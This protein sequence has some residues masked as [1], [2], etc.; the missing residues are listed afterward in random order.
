MTN[1]YVTPEMIQS[2]LTESYLVKRKRKSFLETVLELYEKG[3]Y[4][5]SKDNLT[6]ELLSNTLSDN[7]FEEFLSTYPLQINDI[8]KYNSNYE[9]GESDVMPG[10]TD[11]YVTRQY[12]YESYKIHSHDFLE[13]YYVFK[14]SCDFLFEKENRTLK[15]GDICIVAPNSMHTSI[16]NDNDSIVITIAIKKSTFDIAFFSLLS[17]KDLLSYFFRTILYKKAEPNYL[18]FSTDNSKDIKMILKNLVIE[19]F[20]GDEYFNNCSISWANILFSKI[21]RD[22]GKSAQFYNNDSERDFSSILQYIQHNYRT[23]T[24]KDLA[25]HFH[26]SEAHLSTLIKKNI[27]LNFIALVKKLKMSDAKDYLINTN[28]SIEEIS[29]YIGYNSSNHFSRA[30]KNYYK[31]SPQKYR[32]SL[33]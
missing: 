11:I 1:M 26:Y 22:Y 15:D 9:L 30:F 10:N 32:K 24:L 27:G 33:T 25:E 21:L 31:I 14:G 19:T 3:N 12:T 16:I 2:A 29:E 7:E 6:K 4:I 8:I 20:K 23:L 18:L 5:T 17:Q 28:L 13:I